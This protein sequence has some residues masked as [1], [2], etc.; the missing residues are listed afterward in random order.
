M[1][2]KIL[3]ITICLF[4]FSVLG[5]EATTEKPLLVQES[6]KKFGQIEGVTYCIQESSITLNSCGKQSDW[7]CMEEDGCLN[8]DR[9]VLS[10]EKS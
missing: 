7:P 1:M 8:I 9:W 4:S 6:C 3:A 2:S 10:N 5:L